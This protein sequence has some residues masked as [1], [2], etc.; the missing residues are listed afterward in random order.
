MEILDT[1][2]F[3]LGT[4][5]VARSIE[6]HRAGLR[7]TFEGT[8]ALAEAPSSP[9]GSLDARARYEE[10]GE[11]RFGALGQRAHRRLLYLRQGDSTAMLYF[12][13]GRPFV[14]LDLSA[15]GWT[16]VHLCGHDRYEIATF[17]RSHDVVE[18]HWRV[19]GPAKDYRAV[20]RLMRMRGPDAPIV[21][22]SGL[23]RRQHEEASRHR[24]PSC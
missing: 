6:D 17:V 19:R 18:E 4:W 3:L 24:R 10:V 2:D 11:L 8:A 7:G 9:D 23:P 1:L 21:G 5:R 12:S 22:A 13:D 15:G 14:D 16:S 20:T